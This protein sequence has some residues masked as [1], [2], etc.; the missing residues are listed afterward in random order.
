MTRWFCLKLL[1]SGASRQT[2]IPP[3]FQPAA[4]RGVDNLCVRIT[5]F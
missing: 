3:A 2:E 4:V 1:L 5:G